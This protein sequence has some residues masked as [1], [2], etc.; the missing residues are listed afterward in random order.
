M[1]E[2]GSTWTERSSFPCGILSVSLPEYTW[3]DGKL[4]FLVTSF[5]VNEETLFPNM[6]ITL[7]MEDLI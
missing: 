1:M 6:V 7:Q 2:Q 4:Q 5:I 3:V